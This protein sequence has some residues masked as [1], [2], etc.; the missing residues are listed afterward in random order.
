MP[1]APQAPG[2]NLMLRMLIIDDDAHLR[3]LVATYAQRDNFQCRE[4]ENAVQALELLHQTEYH[5]IIL[6]VM[7]PGKDGFELLEEI[8]RFNQ[9]PVILL[10]ARSEEYDRLTGFRLGADDYVPKPF[11]PREL[12]ARVHAVLRRTRAHQVQPLHYGGM[13][14]DPGA[15]MVTLD[16]SPVS[17]PPKEFD[18]LLTLAQSEHLVF[19]R[20]Q[21]LDKVWGFQYYGDART[22]DTHIKSLREHLGIYRKMIE[23]VWGVGYKF[24]YQEE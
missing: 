18:L 10:T 13:V 24:E 12:M 7:M 16:G 6:D 21:L 19:S 14:I 23:T 3:R 2:R 15:R 22:V 1:A 11:S 9:T 17:L 4:A 5:I 20:E 8:R